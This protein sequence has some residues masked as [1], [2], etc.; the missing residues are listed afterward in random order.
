MKTCGKNA[1]PERFTSNENYTKRN[2]V[3]PCYGYDGTIERV[4]LRARDAQIFPKE[5]TMVFQQESTPVWNKPALLKESVDIIFI[6]EGVPD[7]LSIYTYLEDKRIQLIEK[8][9]EF[10]GDFASIY[11]NSI[12]NHVEVVALPGVKNWRKML[13]EIL[14]TKSQKKK[15]VICFDNDEAGQKSYEQMESE[16]KNRNIL[17]DKFNLGQFKD[18]NDYLVGDKD[19]FYKE[20]TNT[21][22]RIKIRKKLKFKKVQKIN[23][24]K[25]TPR[26]IL[27]RTNN[28]S[29]HTSQEFSGIRNLRLKM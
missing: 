22:E 16:F 7:A 3:I 1:F 26:R 19:A 21:L 6:T 5:L 2:I 4:L 11:T 25:K 17:Y 9:D 27:K 10:E 18:M 14:A 20:M 13:E 12:Y 29:F 8:A 15:F 24:F 28:V 23:N